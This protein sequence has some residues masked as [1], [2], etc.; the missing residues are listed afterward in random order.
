MNGDTVDV[1]EVGVQGLRRKLGLTVLKVSGGC[2]DAQQQGSD[3]SVA[4]ACLKAQVHRGLDKALRNFVLRGTVFQQ[5]PYKRLC[6]AKCAL[7]VYAAS[8][9]FRSYFHVASIFF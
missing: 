2:A 6:G 4:R 3:D 7:G 1:E 8:R 9:I 5:A